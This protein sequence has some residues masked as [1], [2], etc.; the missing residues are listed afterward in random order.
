MKVLLSSSS[1]K[2]IDDYIN[3]KGQCLSLI[4]PN[5]FGK[6]TIA[7]YIAS[8]FLNTDQLS[9]NPNLLVI[10]PDDKGNI[11]ID[12]IRQIN[13]FIKLKATSNLTTPRVIIIK[14]TEVLTKECQNLLLKPLEEPPRDVLFILCASSVQS[15]LPTIQSRIKILNLIPPT[16]KE[17][18]QFFKDDYDEVKLSKSILISQGKLGLLWSMLSNQEH[19]LLEQIDSVKQ[20]IKLNKYQRTSMINDLA[21]SDVT[22][23]LDALFIVA[24]SGFKNSVKS[25]QKQVIFWH[26]L[27]KATFI[28]KKESML[29]G[30]NKL[31][32]T[33]LVLSI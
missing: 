15:L 29:K 31:I 8:K 28:A 1:R 32:L 5:G 20:F 22:S 9:N 19:P 18:K 3:Q 4:A 11:L 16:S 30:N 33:K 6:Y 10:K 12:E 21:K 17:I 27:K 25:N 7:K 14:N 13:A 23:F 2:S 24:D 26:N